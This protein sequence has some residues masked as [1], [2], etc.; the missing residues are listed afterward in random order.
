M[1]PLHRP[2]HERIDWLFGL[3]ERHAQDYASPEAWLARHAPQPH[4]LPGEHPGDGLQAVGGL[5]QKRLPVST[6]ALAPAW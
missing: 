1:A 3:A 2:I 4:R 5:T 6:A